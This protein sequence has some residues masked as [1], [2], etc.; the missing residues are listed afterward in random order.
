MV[1]D[2]PLGGNVREGADIRLE[3]VSSILTTT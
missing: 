2:H 3:E 1:T